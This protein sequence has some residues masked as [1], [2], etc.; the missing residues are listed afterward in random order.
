MK[1]GTRTLKS[2]LGECLERV[3]AG[4]VVYVTDRGKVVAEIRSTQATQAAEEGEEEILRR[5]AAEG[6]V[7][8]GEGPHED[9]EPFPVA[10]RGKRA[11]QMIIEDRS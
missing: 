6:L 4:E 2:R 11:S 5:L 9:F 3:K 7:T 10:H 8:L 1:V